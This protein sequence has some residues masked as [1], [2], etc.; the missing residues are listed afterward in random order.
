ME[1][2]LSSSPLPNVPRAEG[3]LSSSPLP[4]GLA[5]KLAQ[6]EGVAN[7]LNLGITPTPMRLKDKLED[8]VPSIATP[9]PATKLTHV[10]VPRTA[11]SLPDAAAFLAR[12]D[13]PEAERKEIQVAQAG[14]EVPAP[15]P[16][17][18]SHHYLDH[19]ESSPAAP[20]LIA[21][22]GLLTS[23]DYL[24]ALL[25]TL[26]V[27]EQ[28]TGTAPVIDA[29]TQFNDVFNDLKDQEE[30]GNLAPFAIV[31]AGLP[32]GN[33]A[34][35]SR[36]VSVESRY[37]LL[38]FLQFRMKQG[39]DAGNAELAEAY[40][41]RTMA[42]ADRAMRDDIAHPLQSDVMHYYYDT[43]V[44]VGGKTYEECVAYLQAAV[45]QGEPTIA[46]WTAR[47]L[48]AEIYTLTHSNP[49][50]RTL[51]FGSMID[52]L[53]TA[54][55]LSALDDPGA[56]TWLQAA[57][58]LSVG[59][60]YYGLGDFDQAS[61]YFNNTFNY[62]T[63]KEPKA[64]AMYLL[65]DIA[66]R[67]NP[68]NPEIAIERYQA[69]LAK[70]PNDV[71][72]DAGLLNMAA[73]YHA[74]GD[75]PQAL[76][77]YQE[78][79]DRYGDTRSAPVAR[80]EIEYILSNQQGT[81]EVVAAAKEIPAPES[82]APLAMHCGPQALQKLLA[83]RG[84]ESTVDELAALAG[85]DEAGTAM[86]GL[87]RA[88]SAKGLALSGVKT[89][90]LADLAAPFVA[91]LDASHFVLVAEVREQELLISDSGQ[92][93]RPMVL[94]DFSAR[95]KGE[96][97]VLS[98]G[99][100]PLARLLAPETMEALRGGG[101]PDSSQTDKS[102]TECENGCDSCTVPQG[103]ANS[104]INGFAG[105]PACSA[106]GGLGGGNLPNI[107]TGNG[108]G[109]GGG[110]GAVV[111]EVVMGP[112]EQ[113]RKGPD[114]LGV[115]T[116]HSP[117]ASSGFNAPGV[118]AEINTFETSLDLNETDLSLRTLDVWGL[119]FRR[120]YR[121]EGGFHRPET[122]GTSKWWENNIGAGWSHSLN[123]HLQTSSG[124][125]PTTVL[126]WDESGTYRTYELASTAG[127]Y[128]LYERSSTGNPEELGNVLK[129][130]TTTMRFTLEMASGARI[131]F[132]AATATDRVA[133]VESLVDSMGNTVTF[134]YDNADVALGRLTKVQSP[135]GDA[136][137]LALTYSGNLITSVQLKKNSTV[138]NSV[139]FAYNGSSELV[140]VTDHASKTVEYEY[141][142]DGSA[143]GSRFITQITN[144]RGVE[145]DL[146][147][148][149]GLNSLSN[150]EAYKIEV[151]NVAGLTTVYDRSLTT[152]VCTVSN[153][154]GVTLLDKLVNTPV[155]GDKSLSHYID[156]YIDATNYE[157]WTY[158]Y[159]A[160][161]NMTEVTAPGSVAYAEYTYNAMGN[162]LTEAT[163]TGPVT[164][165][166]Y[167]VT[168]SLL[169][170]RIA[171]SGLETVYEYGADNLVSK[172]THPAIDAAGIRFEYDAYGNMTKDIS[173]LGTETTYTYDALGRL[174]E[175]VQ[176]PGGPAITKSYV[177]DDLGNMAEF[178][179][180]RGK[181]TTYAY[182]DPS[183]GACGGGSKLEKITD[184][185][186][187]E[188]EWIYNADGLLEST[189][190]PSGI[191]TD[192]AYDDMGRV[193]TI[194]HPAGS[195]ITSTIVYDK[196]GRV[197]SYTDF[198]GSTTSYEYDHMG[199]TVKVTDAVGD[200]D[201]AYNSLGQLVT[202]TDSLGH[203]TTNTYDTAFRLTEVTDEIGKETHYFY[204]A[205]GRS[206]SVGA[207]TSGTVDPTTYT[208]SSTT[209]L[210]E[211]LEY[212]TSTYTANYE[213]DGDGRLVKLTD[214]I[215]A[216]D[217]LRYGYDAVGRLETI[218]DYDDSVLTYT[219]DDGGNVL[220][221]VD[222]HG[223]TTSY[224]YNDIGQLDTLTA[225]GSKVWDYTYDAGN[226]L[227][228]VDIPNGMHTEYTYDASGRQ[229][230]I[231]HMDGTTVKQGFDYTFDD[232]GN[233]TRIDQED[234]SYWEYDYDGRERLI[235]A[236]RGNHATPTILATYEYTYDDAD[237]MLSKTV[238]WYDDFE[239]GNF[240]GWSGNTGDYA[241]AGGV[242]KNTPHASLWK[243]LYQTETDA[244]HDVSYKYI[245]YTTTGVAAQH[246]R[247]T[248]GNNRL[249][250]EFNPDKIH[251]RQVDG[252]TLTTLGTFTT[253]VAED[254]WY[255]VRTIL[256]GS[257]VKVYWGA[258]GAS[259]NEIFSATTTELTTSRAAWFRGSPNSEHGWDDIQ[260]IAG[261]RTTTETFTYNDANEQI[262]HAKNG[263]TTTMTYDD[264]G[265]LAAR[266][267]GTHDATYGYR[268]GSMLHNV[269]SD[270][271]GEGNVTYETGSDRK[272]RS[273]IA[274]VEET[275][276]NYTV[277]F[278]VVSTENDADGSSGTLTMTNVVLLPVLPVSMLVGD[279][280][281]PT[282]ASGY[283]RYY[284]IDHLGNSR[285]A[286]SAS[287]SSVGTY[288]FSPFGREHAHNGLPLESL[289]A[290][291]AG[292]PWD[293]SA[294]LFHFPYRQYSPELSRWTSRDP[295][296]M[297]DGPNVYGYVTGDPLNKIDQDG[298]LG[299]LAGGLILGGIL[300]GLS[301]YCAITG[302]CGEWIPW[303]A[304]TIGGGTPISTSP[305]G[306]GPS[307]GV[308]IYKQLKDLTEDHNRRNTEAFNE[309]FP[310]ASCPIDAPPYY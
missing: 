34:L 278:D 275:W 261:T 303:G 256:D 193:E 35:L 299:W 268:Y 224:T 26:D 2:E 213:Y 197:A 81:V 141:G 204:D 235:E 187:H 139:T 93:E 79:V 85:T 156:Y 21:A 279:L 9:K 56:Y 158:T 162:V 291:Y 17:V 308:E 243:D 254:T 114:K 190:A 270:F 184:A 172:I 284:V 119:S 86:A 306:L 251:L 148:T 75:Y 23:G 22:N 217:G 91:L 92:P 296:G 146:A 125:T 300:G 233:I 67:Q 110:G 53:E 159:D 127:G 151:D 248:D 287:K 134:T 252:G 176:D 265:R 66:A 165:Y 20:A 310:K 104:T 305:I 77:L 226:R 15:T 230:S 52:E 106:G 103:N 210:L 60:A 266:G 117:G 29:Q 209:G 220:S 189:I 307:E 173:P 194:T 169:T 295:L 8:A 166:E 207:G 263:V 89:E 258:E 137:H 90:A 82:P 245:R 223:N 71:N 118:M 24:G 76:Q 212:G 97:L 84:I 234:G 164:E 126:Y 87:V 228:R 112:P 195:A 149:F 107:P 250:L 124:T 121:S 41:R 225:P 102:K 196:L 285:G 116:V 95:W 101:G 14:G 293:D 155:S 191:E 109:G 188:T 48:L 168:G 88:A 257:S 74:Y 36:Y 50:E 132:S 154:D 240:T 37:A 38:E 218:T 247:Y 239:D 200:I 144:K 282:P 72:A 16:R 73:L 215:D 236:I 58:Q 202:V 3:G 170:K 163:G 111:I 136:Q 222:Y 113:C 280:A 62:P 115:G 167:D 309:L 174:E 65:A 221:M 152:S 51:Q 12:L 219:Y 7:T 140:T 150:Y 157:R 4:Q 186:T 30:A 302:S 161:R 128:N 259:F 181:V 31:E 59:Q 201:Y 192:Y 227:T 54:G 145:T 83:L 25:A 123:L 242:L 206:E 274:G 120:A 271:P 272:R 129:R 11:K 42:L 205:A 232:G 45:V 142:S 19:P 94:S 185:L 255:N 304:G 5:Q 277:G 10:P 47:V 43:A 281:G 27:M 6:A 198:G 273:R 122:V 40:A 13:M 28:Y 70:Y 55:I 100:P 297:G 267:D 264:W 80:Q 253:T 175:V 160:A 138:L 68:Y 199:R 49:P 64:A 260:L 44:F 276:Y 241:V 286:W 182:G 231:H 99:V 290:S 96:A 143:A 269:T 178:T 108:G 292:K 133:R 171:P 301:I 244:D 179:D 78:V 180:P 46:R 237:N 98:D 32:R 283:A 211:S 214:W 229:D 246:L 61:V 249:Y 183:C 289:A 39:L 208:Y 131:E 147:W 262:T 216:V 238:P 33:D 288:E 298:R 57:L 105:P 18:S 153:W 135:A 63:G 1:G 130:D 177:Y 203:E 69:F 294:R